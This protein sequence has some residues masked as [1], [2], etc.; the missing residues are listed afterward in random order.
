M[1]DNQKHLALK[2]AKFH[3]VLMDATL[4]YSMNRLGESKEFDIRDYPE[5]L[6]TYIN[7][8]LHNEYD[9]SQ[10]LVM[11]LSNNGML[12]SGKCLP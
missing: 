3:E 12:V 2:I 11:Y 8:Y 7:M 4:S 5:N 6:H 9:S 10:L 1:N